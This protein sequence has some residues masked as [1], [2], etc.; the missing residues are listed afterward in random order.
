MVSPLEQPRRRY[1]RDPSA[2]V[3]STPPP[4]SR[5]RRKASSGSPAPGAIATPASCASGRT[6]GPRSCR[7]S[8]SRSRSVGSSFDQRRRVAQRPVPQG[9]PGPWAFPTDQARPSNASISPCAGSTPPAAGG[10][11]GHTLETRPQPFAPCSKAH[12][13]QRIGP[14]GPAYTVRSTLPEHALQS[15]PSAGIADGSNSGS[16]AGA[17]GRE[18][19]LVQLGPRVLQHRSTRERPRLWGANRQGG[20]RLPG[21]TEA[22]RTAASSEAWLRTPC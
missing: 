18:E 20:W 15:D 19:V 8:P 7:S 9:D 10:N 13:P 22:R 4:P 21:S 16:N 2:F 6:R 14:S 3:T 1:A 5:P 11:T 17:V 12:R